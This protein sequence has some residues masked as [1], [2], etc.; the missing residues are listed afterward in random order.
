MATT[1]NFSTS[2]SKNVHLQLELAASGPPLQAT[3]SSMLSNIHRWD[4]SPVYVRQVSTLTLVR[5]SCILN[6][7]GG[8]GDVRRVMWMPG[9]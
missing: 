8:H 1:L 9:I 7:T 3:A 5:M 2:L 6:A 4:C